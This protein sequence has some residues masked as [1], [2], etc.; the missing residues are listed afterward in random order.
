M[1]ADVGDRNQRA[2]ATGAPLIHLRLQVRHTVPPFS[3]HLI[4]VVSRVGG[5]TVTDVGRL[6]EQVGTDCRTPSLPHHGDAARAD[7][8][9]DQVLLL[10][11]GPIR[12]IHHCTYLVF[13]FRAYLELCHL[14]P[15]PF[16]PLYRQVSIA[17]AHT[18][19]TYQTLQNLFGK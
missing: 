7:R 1:S 17:L 18:L 12:Q 3:S 11:P 9:V 10:G 4:H 13:C 19:A 5:G 15:N 2:D 14:P 6:G 16:L 8:E